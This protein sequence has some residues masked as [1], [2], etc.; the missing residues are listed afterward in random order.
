MKNLIKKFAKS[1]LTIGLSATILLSACGGTEQDQGEV[2]TS[3]QVFGGLA[4]DGY[5]ARATVF[6]DTNNDGT[7]NAWEPFAFTDDEGYY[8]FNPNQNINYCA[9][10][11]TSEQSQ[12]CLQT[13]TYRSD[14]V[15][16]IDGGY[17][18]STGEPFTGQLSRRL[19]DV[20]EGGVNDTLITPI[21]SLLTNIETD[22]DQ[23]ALLSSLNL[24]IED[25][26]VNYLNDD[27]M[28]GINSK[29]L[30]AAIKVH[31]TVTVLSDRLTDTYDEIGDSFGTPNDAT[32]ILYF[33]LG[34]QLL[35]SNLSFDDLT[36]NAIE[37]TEV[38]DNAETSLRDIY[39]RKD[40][41]LP[42]DLGSVNNPTNFS[43]IID[44]TSY[45]VDVTNTVIPPNSL[46]EAPEVLGAVRAVETLVIKTLN[47]VGTDFSIDNA[48][49]FFTGTD[50]DLIDTL[51]DNLS[52]ETAD[53]ISLVNNGFVSTDFDTITEVE[54]KGKLAD[55]VQPFTQIGGLSLKVSDLDLGSYP[56][57]LED[58]E[59][60][61]Y[62]SGLATDRSGEF[63]ACVKYID[64]ASIDGSLGEGNTRGELIDGYW[65]LLG[66]S[67]SSIES[68]S[69]LLTITFLGTS[70]QA[71]LKPAGE[72]IISEVT[73][74][75]LRFDNNGEFDT[76]HSEDGFISAVSIPTTNN[77]CQE[78]LPSRVGI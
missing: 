59:A 42:A 65:S 72:E 8:S 11:A 74:Q 44:V 19:T 28:G 6:L 41:D 60:E 20:E 45:L 7:R 64:D 16:R 38:L 69:V 50:T 39:E 68:Y 4:I 2:S 13:N 76:Y 78:R 77:E 63:S 33:Q 70:Y 43:R 32:N 73:Y 29:I 31:K 17:D 49:S 25:I 52:D 3:Q 40:F 23:S 24:T 47:E 46:I 51:L 66:S 55:D 75:K 37:L 21:S 71:I 53:I 36:N 15:V 26:D 10:T 14:V 18:I 54:S 30:N 5:L 62:F 57:K 48:I 12:Y 34:S 9:D 58:S 61:F 22:A 35:T 67:E 27:G 56:D 1:K